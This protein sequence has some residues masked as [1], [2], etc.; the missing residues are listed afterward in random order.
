M[1]LNFYNLCLRRLLLDLGPGSGVCS[2]Y[3]IHES[4]WMQY[5]HIPEYMLFLKVN[6]HNGVLLSHK[7]THLNQF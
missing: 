7:E 1:G 6:I 4:L 5:I 3:K 2:V